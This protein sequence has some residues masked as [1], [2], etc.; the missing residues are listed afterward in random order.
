MLLGYARGS[1]SNQ[2][3]FSLDGEARDL[4]LNFHKH[5]RMHIGIQAIYEF[6][7]LTNSDPELRVLW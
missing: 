7:N 1:E 4:S 3:R 6:S 2:W 5:L